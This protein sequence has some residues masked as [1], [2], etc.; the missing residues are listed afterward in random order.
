MTQC[1]S[2]G[3]VCI[4]Q[5][6]GHQLMSWRTNVNISTSLAKVYCWITAALRIYKRS[7]KR[8][9]HRGGRKIVKFINPIRSSPRLTTSQQTEQNIH[10]LISIPLCKTDPQRELGVDV[11]MHRSALKTSDVLAVKETWFDVNDA[12]VVSEPCGT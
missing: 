12:I 2:V 3:A 9:L 10:N 7:T 4:G 11:L 5:Y 6:T 8:R 1:I